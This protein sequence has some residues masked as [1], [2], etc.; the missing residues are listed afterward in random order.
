MKLVMQGVTTIAAG[1]TDP[2]V[3]SGQKYNRPPM[4]A[5]ATLYCTGSAL[6]LTAEMNINGLANTDK[7]AVND[8]NRFP[9]VPDDLLSTDMEAPQG[10]LMQLSVT[11]NDPTNNLDFFW[12]V[13]LDDAVMV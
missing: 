13:E 2:D 10:G 5:I 4:N 12:R 3:L 6:G 7:I 1:T 8:Q 9:V 11:N